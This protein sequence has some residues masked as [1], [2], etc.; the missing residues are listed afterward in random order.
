MCI[1]FISIAHKMKCFFYYVILFFQLKKIYLYYIFLLNSL[2]P[3]VDF[4]RR[5]HRLICEKLLMSIDI[6]IIEHLNRK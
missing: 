4:H 6:S 5:F 3:T 1:K 2:D